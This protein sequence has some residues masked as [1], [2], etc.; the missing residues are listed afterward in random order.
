MPLITYDQIK[1]SLSSG[2]GLNIN[3]T[4]TGSDISVEGQFTG[5]TGIDVP[6]LPK[7]D[8]PM[9]D[10]SYSNTL[11]GT[12]Q[13][14][15]KL[16]SLKSG[17]G[18]KQNNFAG[19]QIIINSDR[20]IFNS[21]VDYLMLF[22]QSGVAIASPGNVNID[23]E[24]GITLFGEDGVYIGIPGK[25]VAKGNKVE[26]QTK[27]QP[28]IDSDYEP[29]LLGAKVAN[30]IEDLLITLKNA[31]ILTPVGKAYFREDTLHD[32]ASLQS[33]LP[34]IL[35]TY[36]YIDGISHEGVDPAPAPLQVTTPAPT[37]ITGTISS[38]GTFTAVTEAI[39]PDAATQ[40]ITNPL[41]TQTDFFDPKNLYNE[42][43]Q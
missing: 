7:I 12:K 38:T 37:T 42:P 15:N 14:L 11:Q 16:L 30:L 35:S 1:Q 36:A 8:F 9:E 31:T 22:G 25:G 17:K 21:R 34:E 18:G 39:N 33:R 3:P 13:D 27:A 28:T 24:D 10:L 5:V 26:P 23:S 43:N 6:Q 41:S 29:L 32:L 19:S 20:L 2:G 4:G 40:A